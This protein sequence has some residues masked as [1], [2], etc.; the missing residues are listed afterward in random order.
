MRIE[1]V[2]YIGKEANKLEVVDAGM[3]HR[4]SDVYTEYVDPRREPEAWKQNILPSLKAMPLSKLQ[5]LTGI[6]RAAL[7]AIRAGRMPHPRN[8]ARLVRALVDQPARTG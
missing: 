3:V 4:A 7:Q 1:S 5:K 8:R 2:R 6:S